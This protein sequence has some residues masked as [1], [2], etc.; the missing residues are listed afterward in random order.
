MKIA[1]ESEISRYKERFEQLR[2]QYKPELEADFLKSQEEL[3]EV[4]YILEK[5]NEILN[6]IY[7]NFN[8]KN[9]LVHTDSFKFKELEMCSYIKNLL[10]K[11]YNDNKY[12]LEVVSQQEAEKKDSNIQVNLPYVNNAIVKNKLL[13]DIRDDLTK[14][15][16]SNDESF[17]KMS[18]LMKFIN[19]NFADIT[20]DYK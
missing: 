19:N 5:S 12:L 17:K 7:Q 6:P 8:N 1:H 11:F 15:E 3:E 18:E 10:M 16:R 13:L 4:R 14:V 2:Y 9:L 20:D